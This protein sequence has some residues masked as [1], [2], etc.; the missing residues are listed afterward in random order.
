MAPSW[1]GSSITALSFRAATKEAY[2]FADYAQHWIKYLTF[3]A[4]GGVSGV[5]NFEPPDG[6]PTDPTATSCI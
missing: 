1:A 3:D 6:T 5:F 2:F 4:N